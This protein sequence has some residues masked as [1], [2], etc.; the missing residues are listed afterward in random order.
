MTTVLRFRR[1]TN[2][3]SFITVVAYLFVFCPGTFTI[4]LYK[5]ASA[6]PRECIIP[7]FCLTFFSESKDLMLSDPH[8]F[9]VSLNFQRTQELL[10]GRKGKKLY[11]FVSLRNQTKHFYMCLNYSFCSP[12]DLF[13][14]AVWIFQL[15]SLMPG[16]P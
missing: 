5:Q 7:T 15:V 16:Q 13:A 3:F 2:Y 1:E 6:H 12:S 4:H 8:I 9:Q 11:S 14:F 10:E